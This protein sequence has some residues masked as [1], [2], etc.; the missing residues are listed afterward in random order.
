MSDLKLAEASQI[1]QTFLTCTFADIFGVLAKVA[2]TPSSKEELRDR[3]QR[4]MDTHGLMLTLVPASLCSALRPKLTLS[5]QKTHHLS[6]VHIDTDGSFFTKILLIRYVM[7]T[8]SSALGV[9]S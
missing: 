8:F 6:Y 5:T 2:D 3:M 7:S 1:S 4:M 9:L